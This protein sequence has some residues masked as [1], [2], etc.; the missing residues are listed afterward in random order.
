MNNKYLIDLCNNLKNNNINFNIINTQS[1]C[2][3]S[4]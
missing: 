2:K 1:N 3:F 4:G